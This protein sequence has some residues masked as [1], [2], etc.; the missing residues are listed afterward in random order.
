MV[1]ENHLTGK[2]DLQKT[3]NGMGSS[4]FL[5]N[6]QVLI[7][8]C[9]QNYNIVE[10]SNK[11][12]ELLGYK[13]E[14]IVGKS[15]LDIIYPEDIEEFQKAFKNQ[16]SVQVR[17]KPLNKEPVWCCIS[18]NKYKFDNQEFV[19]YIAFDVSELVKG[20][21]KIARLNS[22]LSSI[23]RVN[24]LLLKKYE[25]GEIFTKTC[26]IFIDS[27][28]FHYASFM[29]YIEDFD[30]Y[31]IFSHSGEK[32]S[33]ITEEE[34]IARKLYEIFPFI[35]NSVDDNSIVIIND[36]KSLQ[37]TT[38]GMLE[39]IEKDFKSICVIPIYCG[40]N[41]FGLFLFCSKRSWIVD[42]ESL[43]LLEEWKDNVEFGLKDFFKDRHILEET[44]KKEL[45]FDRSPSGFLLVSEEG[46][47]VETNQSFAELV[48]LS[49]KEITSKTIF[50]IFP[51][52]EEPL[53]NMFKMLL[54]RKNVEIEIPV[55]FDG[56]IRW[57]QLVGEYVFEFNLYLLI[58]KDITEKKEYEKELE[59]QKQKAL[60]LERLKTNIL[61]NISHEFR[62]PLNGILGFAKY[63]RDSVGD[64]E[65]KEFLV[66]IYE[67]AY[68]LFRTLESLIYTS[69]IVS[70]N[71]K[72]RKEIFDLK[73]FLENLYMELKNIFKRN[74]I[75]L[76]LEINCDECLVDSD[77]EFLKTIIYSL[78]ENAVKF[79]VKGEIV[80]RAYKILEP[81]RDKL[82]IEV[83]DTGIGI[84]KDIGN[85][86]FEIFRQGS[87]GISRNYEGHG[88]GLFNVKMLTELLCGTVSYESEVGKGTTFRIIF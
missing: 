68:R 28:L 85:K 60:E 30:K 24:Q 50:D 5:R 73:I 7:F 37:K 61:Q 36:L 17:L 8:V 41:F 27:G 54:E 48:S 66:E 15:F 58:C 78:V 71:L 31:V 81:D 38:P 53:R 32:I 84:S 12:E 57:L 45:F 2:E 64:E 75:E 29:K 83:S 87:E 19:Y 69:Q 47:I 51:K 4:V 16:N 14:E 49:L 21:E 42:N 55:N 62:T 46:K 86:I 88:V 52:S 67:S 22:F 20:K 11:V 82:V 3:L 39:L 25:L 59:I 34:L 23:S 70:G 43:Q 1:N 76:R 6:S 79:T 72:P 74:T 26:E 13:N 44:F 80:I 35:K 10:I 63:L 33:G 77:A 40:K 65:I 18:I 9:D 56:T